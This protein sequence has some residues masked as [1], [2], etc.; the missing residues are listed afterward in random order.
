MNLLDDTISKN[1]RYFDASG[2]LFTI[3]NNLD[4]NIDEV[5]FRQ[6]IKDLVFCPKISQNMDGLVVINGIKENN[7]YDVL[8]YNPDGSTG[9]MCGNG[10]RCFV[11][12]CYQYL[13]HSSPTPDKIYFTINGVRYHGSMRNNLISITFPPPNKKPEE[14]CFEVDGLSVCGYFIDVGTP[15]FVIQTKNPIEDID[16][17]AAATSILSQKCFSPNGTN[18]NYYQIIDKNTLRVRTFERGVNH[19]TGSCGTGAIATAIIYSQSIN[20]SNNIKI[21]PTSKSELIAE[22]EYDAKNVLTGITLSGEV[23]EL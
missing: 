8:F 2:N 22:M 10:S 23:A 11:Y 9:M 19:E 16:I 5:L 4:A 7:C 3:F 12:Y 18:V 6:N 13:T 20:G 14:I 21:I 1:V 15:H 17:N